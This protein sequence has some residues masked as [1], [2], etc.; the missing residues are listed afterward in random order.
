MAVTLTALLLLGGLSSA[1]FA[2]STVNA[3]TS[4]SGTGFV[5]SDSVG[6]TKLPIGEVVQLI[7]ASGGVIHAPN[8]DGSPSGGDVVIKTGAIAGAAGLAYL[9]S[10]E[11]NGSVVYMRAWNGVPSDPTATYGNSTTYTIVDPSPPAPLNWAISVGFATTMTKSSTP[12]LVSIAVTPTAPSM[13]VGGTQQFT[14]TG[15]YSDS[16]TANITSS[17]T[18]AS[19]TPATATINSAGLA[20]GVAAGT[21]A[22]TATSGSIVSPAVTLTVNATGTL[23]ITTSSLPNGTQNTAYSQTL[24]ATGGTTPY[25]W[26]IQ[27]GSLPAGLT[28]SSGGV[29]SG[30]PTT[31]GTSNFT[32]Q[33]ADAASGTDTQALS[34]TIASGSSGTA[35]TI[36]S[37]TTKDSTDTSGYIYDAIDITGTNFGGSGSSTAPTGA[38]VELMS[39]GGSYVTLPSSNIYWWQSDKI[40]IGLPYSVGSTYITAGTATIRVTTTTGSA[41]GSFAIKPKVYSVSP[42][43]GAVGSTVRIEGTGFS[44]TAAN[45]TVNFAGATTSASAFTGGS[46]VSTLEVAVPASAASGQLLVNV[47]SQSSNT[48]Y[49]WS[50]YGPIVFTVTGGSGA[51]DSLTITS[52]NG[53]E[54][55]YP[56]IIPTITWT[57]TGSIANVRIDLSTDGGTT[58]ASTYET[59]T[60]NDG[61]YTLPSALNPTGSFANCRIRVSDAADQVPYDISDAAFT[62]TNSTDSYSVISVSPAAAPAGARILVSYISGR[63]FGSS[64]GRSKLVFTNLTT[65]ASSDFVEI[66][67][68]TD[69]SIEAVTPR[70]TPGSYEVTVSY[71]PQVAGATVFESNP[72]DF[73]ITALGAAGV[74]T[75]YPNPFNAGQETVNLIVTNTTGVSNFG[76]YIYDMTAQLVNKQVLTVGRTTWDGRTTAGTVAADGVYLLRVVNEDTKTLLAK[77]KILV[78]KR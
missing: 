61:S 12:T 42:T 3:Y 16:S 64:E 74:A 22:I 17:V 60:P 19:G 48:N 9:T 24:A 26:S 39:Q 41:T 18:W 2:S 13:N 77:G 37:V 36:T 78:I 10:T 63:T 68:W 54:L 51:T 47:N 14:A 33:V 57:S 32:I 27:A 50:P 30:I 7:R 35:P 15:T 5:Y 43:S 20:T 76:F 31:I 44:S 45:N 73:S 53:G 23:T 25:T 49:D 62:I 58:W 75:V 21:T 52:P 70:L 55:W 71:I 59:S 11:A 56:G 67:N 46:S 8:S 38:S 34:L 65:G 72:D 69:T 4:G 6:G 28:L 1:A 29:I 66:R 40:Q